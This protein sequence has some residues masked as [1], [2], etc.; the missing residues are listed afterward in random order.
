M[1]FVGVTLMFLT[2]YA[3]LYAAEQSQIQKIEN[4]ADQPR[5]TEDVF[6]PKP[7]LIMRQD[8]AASKLDTGDTSRIFAC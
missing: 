3:T 2:T 5:A 6:L 8:P 4:I 1:F 7:E